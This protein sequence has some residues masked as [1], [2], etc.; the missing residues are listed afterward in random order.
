MDR[1][2]KFSPFIPSTQCKQFCIRL[3]ALFASG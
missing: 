1:R 2:Q 3:L